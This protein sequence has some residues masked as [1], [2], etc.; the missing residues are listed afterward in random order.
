MQRIVIC[1]ICLISLIFLLLT[2]C[3]KRPINNPYPVSDDYKNI[4]YASFSE[5]PKTLDPARAYSTNEAIFV[6]QIYEP[7]LQ[8]HYLKRPY[9]LIPLIATKIPQPIF[10]DKAGKVLPNNTSIDNIIYSVY[11][12]HINPGIYY[13]PHPAF[14]R[15]T[16]GQYYYHHL[17]KQ[18]LTN[19]Q[20]LKDFKHVGTRELIAEDYV[21]QIK[22]IADPNVQS[23]VYGFLNDYIVGLTELNKTL[24]DIY[25]KQAK[26]KQNK[27]L[28]LRQFNFPGAEVIDKY[29]YRIKLKGY[30]P[31]FLYWLAMPF[32][33]PM[34][35]EADFFYNQP[36]MSDSNISLDWYPV[37]TGPYILQENNPN[38]RMILTR[39][40]NFHAE[41]YPNDGSV[42]DKNLL[43]LAGKKLPFIDQFM[44]T[45][46]KESIPRW[47]KFLQGY[48]DQSAVGSDSFDQAI[49]LNEKGL[50]ELT[51]ELKNKSLRLQTEIVPG[52]YYVGFNML[53]ATVGGYNESACKLRQAIGIA[54]D[55]EEFIAIFL[56]GRGVVAQGPIPPGIF[57][58]TTKFDT[59]I[60]AKKN[61]AIQRKNII[62][63]KKLLQEAGYPNGIDKQSGK[64]LLLNFDIM[65]GGTADD[66]ALFAWLRKQFAKL[67]IELQIRDTQYNRFQDKVRTGQAQIFFWGWNADYPD[68]ENFLFLL[69]G[70]NGKVKFGGE[71]ASNYSN[72][73]YDRLFVKMRNLPNGNERQAVIDK[74]ISI[75][76]HDAPWIWGYHP[77]NFILTQN[78]VLPTKPN[79]VANN[80][81]KYIKINIPERLQKQYAW[82]Q[83]IWWPLWLLLILIFLSFIPVIIYYWNK[84][85][86]Q[87]N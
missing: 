29:T 40:P 49:E 61:N 86:K 64:A 57:G 48:Y 79:G 60:Y 37:G 70:P 74:M 45:L 3:G 59:Y 20:I 6:A 50:P 85:H 27:F 22:R 58:Y 54:I 65:S 11:E 7:P 4:Y 10:L 80:T 41:F 15:D 17:T 36:G 62:E 34:P 51:S 63:A 38:R 87:Q 52:N 72:P 32:F 24:N 21:Y 16:H 13:Q 39:N 43:A 66:K 12:I 53:D 1:Q 68:P 73:A 33:A 2:A 55:M 82:N 47:A 28:D 30:Y 81:L 42:D 84:Q 56:N 77:E 26:Y 78:W 35:W 9:S 69:Y 23:P 44:F 31:Q 76:Q 75:V 83:P 8:Y 5:Q 46:E 71:N 14:A 25:F 18:D 67:N 19:I